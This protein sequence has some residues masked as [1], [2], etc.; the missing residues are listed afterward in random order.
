MKNFASYLSEKRYLCL[1]NQLLKMLE[2][3]FCHHHFRELLETQVNEGFKK[4]LDEN[5]VKL[6][7]FGMALNS[8]G[9][10]YNRFG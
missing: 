1:A 5:L 7:K 10:V 2:P 6:K 3:S 9:S 8:C 4:L